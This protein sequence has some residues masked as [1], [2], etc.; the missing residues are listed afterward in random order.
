MQHKMPKAQGHP[1]RKSCNHVLAVHHLAHGDLTLQTHLQRGN[2][3][4]QPEIAVRTSLTV[5]PLFGTCMSRAC[6]AALL[7]T[8]RD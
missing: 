8:A 7:G 2:L 3:Q 1:C 6:G 5:M 4:K